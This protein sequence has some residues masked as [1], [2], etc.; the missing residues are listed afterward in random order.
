[1][2]VHPGENAMNMRLFYIVALLILPLSGC[3][4][5]S[6]G[7]NYADVYL[8]YTINSYADFNDA[9][10]KAISLEVNDFMRWH[11]RD[12]LP[13]YIDFL[14]ELQQVVQSGAPLKQ[15]DVARFREEMRSLYVKTMQPTVKPA[16]TV[17]SGVKGG[18]IEELAKSFYKENGK[19][20]DKEL[21]GSPDEQLRKR[22]E[23][24][25][26]FVE[27]LVGGLSDMQ[28]EKIR[29]MSRRLPYATALYIRLREDNQARLLEMLRDKKTKSEIADF[30]ELWLLTPEAS[31][32]EEEQRILQDFEI[33]SEE[34]VVNIYQMLTERQ[35]ETLLKNIVKYI[36]TFQG[37]VNAG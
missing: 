30:L 7:Y 22:A 5:I 13:V 10:K 35:R 3:G 25:I 20:R 26:D 18:Q 34:M 9:Q 14:K 33:A 32:S 11:R 6:V 21:S 2:S 15:E 31:R 17:L 23:R 36:N 28:L 1:M 37:L 27:T 8:R 4:I 24:T 19:Q 12:M 16:A 29:N